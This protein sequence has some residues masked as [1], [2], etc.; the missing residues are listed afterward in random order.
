[1]D[2]VSPV[3]EP[4]A[5]P[6]KNSANAIWAGVI[7]VVILIGAGAYAYTN[8]TPPT[9]PA[10][11]LPDYYP[12]DTSAAP[13]TESGDPVPL[14]PSQISW[15]SITGADP[16]SDTDGTV[17]YKIGTITRGS[18]AGENLYLRS[19]SE[20]VNG[21][22][23][24]FAGIKSLIA[25]DIFV[26]S[27]PAKPVQVVTVAGMFP[28]DVY[29]TNPVD[30]NGGRLDVTTLMYLPKSASMITPVP[31]HPTY[32]G[33][34]VVSIPRTSVPADPVDGLNMS[35]FGL[36]TPFGGIYDINPEPN[37]IDSE[38]Y[39]VP[40]VTWLQGTTTVAD[41]DY[42][43]YG[44]GVSGD[45]LTSFADA[46]AL[47]ASFVKTGVTV[48]GDP[49]YEVNPVGHDDFYHCFY[50]KT[51]EHTYNE[52]TGDITSSYYPYT[53][54][55]FLT[56]HNVFFWQ[57]SYGNWFSFTS[58]AV[59]PNFGKAKPVI[60]LYPTHTEDVS[61]QVNP[62]GGFTKTDPAY[63]SG[64]NVRATPQGILTNLADQKTYPYLFWEGGQSGAVTIPSRG[65]V[66]S[67]DGVST[68]LDQKLALLGLNSTERR[69]FI[70]FWAPKMSTSPY[71]FITFVPQSEMDR[72]APLTVNPAP[73]TVIRVL[74]DY[75]PLTAPI[76]VLPLEISTPQ[77]HGFTLVEWGGLIPK[78]GFN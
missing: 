53:Y 67:K 73:D 5:T 17:V 49:V 75:R 74:M 1:M 33:D 11:T 43:D 6:P 26:G 30:S 57:H 4:T 29:D 39:Y 12:S 52:D 55:E 54:A 61:I 8:G 69:D 34:V 28:R 64:W 62:V 42:G 56:Q 37:F 46:S 16:V 31:N 63:G 77:R 44:L 19:D 51:E 21:P 18:Y 15:V 68:L 9:S 14:D 23:E 58:L 78:G 72:V 48:H 20:S 36:E 45:C 71:Y 27:S 59:T 50:A 2:P 60:Y 10:Y 76:P 22:D 7:I 40:Q 3:Q 66:V 24:K 13:D 65:F 32:A 25:P 70:A 41:Y 35:Y 38:E 47:R